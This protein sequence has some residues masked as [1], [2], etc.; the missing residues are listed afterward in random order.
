M[1]TT[2]EEESED[3][4]S[5]LVTDRDQWLRQHEAHLLNGATSSIK[6]ES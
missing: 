6:F 1:E 4:D 2:N 3:L 5:N